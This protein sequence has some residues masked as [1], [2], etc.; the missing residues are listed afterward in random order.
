MGI[1]VYAYI[2][3]SKIGLTKI[4]QVEVKAFNCG[5]N[6]IHNRDGKNLLLEKLIRHIVDFLLQDRVLQSSIIIQL[7]EKV[8]GEIANAEKTTIR[9]VNRRKSTSTASDTHT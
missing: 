8:V 1:A 2:I 7:A 5:N 6:C 4:F 9:G 3:I